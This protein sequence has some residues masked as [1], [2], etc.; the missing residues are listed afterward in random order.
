M[1]LNIMFRRLLISVSSDLQSVRIDSSIVFYFKVNLCFLP[2]EIFPLRNP[3]SS[4]ILALESWVLTKI[5]LQESW[6]NTK[7]EK[8][9][10]YFKRSCKAHPAA[11]RVLR[12]RKTFAQIKSICCKEKCDTSYLPKGMTFLELYQLKLEMD[13][14]I[15][16]SMDKLWDS[17]RL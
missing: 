13:E 3:E 15:Q 7:V 1:H 2:K 16:G 9:K 14:E 12:H 6:V 17:R 11:T 4:Q 10:S 8:I 5:S